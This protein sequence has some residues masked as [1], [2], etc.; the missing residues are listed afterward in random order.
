MT[1]D[2]MKAALKMP[3][4][5]AAQPDCP[6]PVVVFIEPDTPGGDTAFGTLTSDEAFILVRQLLEAIHKAGQE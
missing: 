1:T 5:A 3:V 2:Q 4:T 6:R